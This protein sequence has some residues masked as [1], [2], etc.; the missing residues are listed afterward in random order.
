VKFKITGSEVIDG[1]LVLDV[2]VLE[3]SLVE[4]AKKQLNDAVTAKDEQMKADIANSGTKSG[5]KFIGAP[6]TQAKMPI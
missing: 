1:A 6:G 5:K 4:E 2:K 3:G